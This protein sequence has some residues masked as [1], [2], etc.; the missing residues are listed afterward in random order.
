[1][2]ACPQRERVCVCVRLPNT[3]EYGDEGSR[4]GSWYSLQVHPACLG[5]W[6]TKRSDS[7]NTICEICNSPYE[8][9]V[10]RSAFA[11]RPPHVVR[12]TTCARDTETRRTLRTDAY[13][14]MLLMYAAAAADENDHHAGVH[15]NRS[16]LCSRASIGFFSEA[17]TML[18]CLV[19]L[20]WVFV[21]SHDWK[22]SNEADNTDVRHIR[23]DAGEPVFWLVLTIGC[24]MVCFT[25]YTLR[26]V[27]TRTCVSPPP[28]PALDQLHHP[29]SPRAGKTHLRAQGA[30]LH[31][32]TPPAFSAVSS[33]TVV[34]CL[35]RVYCH[36]FTSAARGT[37]A[38]AQGSGLDARYSAVCGADD[39]HVAAS[40]VHRQYSRAAA[41]VMKEVSRRQV[42]LNSHAACSPLFRSSIS[43]S[44]RS[45]HAAH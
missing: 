19:S 31:G 26:K 28:R 21:V 20:L 10:V 38:A 32:C 24:G 27:R 5:E 45:V 14:L 2:G 12:Q 44:P 17:C 34:V 11:R 16:L 15:W 22:P 7:H 23:A 33:C 35:F 3:G 6:I 1:M 30:W 39:V 40:R 4:Q 8:V 37:S 36:P 41:R 18:F 42:F 43:I 13:V 25:L 29:S 9:D